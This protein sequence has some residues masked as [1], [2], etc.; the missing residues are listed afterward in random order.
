MRF[1]RAQNSLNDDLF[2]PLY[3]TRGVFW[4]DYYYYEYD[5]INLRHY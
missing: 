1:G 3:E 4:N 5:R 2:K